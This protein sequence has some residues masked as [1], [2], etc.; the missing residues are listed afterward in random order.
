MVVLFGRAENKRGIDD[1]NDNHNYSKIMMMM[2][3]LAMVMMPMMN[4]M[5]MMTMVM[6]M[7]MAKVSC[8]WET[9]MEAPTSKCG[10]LSS[11]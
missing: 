9:G 8:Q 4:M 3:T 6:V 2:M 5:I 10:H 1:Y 7:T 11:R